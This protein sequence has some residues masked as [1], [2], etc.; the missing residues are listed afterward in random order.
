MQQELEDE[1]PGFAIHMI[2][3]NSIGAETGNASMV[4]G[5]EIPWLQDT[6][7]VGASVLWQ[8]EHF[9]LIVLDEENVPILDRNLLDSD[10]MDPI[11]FDE[12]KAF[13]MGAAGG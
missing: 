7:D 5:R 1:M 4:A 11:H 2:G 8:A 10:L 13:L 3:V 12:M 6:V 9:H